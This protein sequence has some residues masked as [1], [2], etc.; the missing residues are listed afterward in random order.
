SNYLATEFEKSFTGK[1][2][3]AEMWVL[4]VAAAN[5]TIFSHGDVNESLELALTS[6]NKMQVT[7]GSK[8]I[9]SA[10]SY[11][12]KPGEWA[13]V[14]VVYNNANQTVSAFYNFVEMIHAAQVNSYS[15][16][17]H[18]EYGRS[19][20][21]TNSYFNGKI[22]EARI[23]ND[24]LNS[25]KLQINSLSVLSGSESALLGYYP[26]NEGKGTVVF[27]KAHG[28]N[29]LLNGL[30]ST[31][32][33][34]AIKLS[35]NGYVKVNTSFAPVTSAMDYTLEMWF[36]ADAS[37]VNA[38]LA[39]NGK[40]D[41]TEFGGSL[42]L[43]NLGFESGLLSF[44][45]NGYKVQADGNYL[46]NKWH[47]VAIAVNRNSGS[48]QLSVDGILNQFF[49]AK[50]LGGIASANT[51]LGV[52]SY[53][54][55]DATTVPKFD[56][57]FTG[58]IDEF[59]IWNTY[60]NQ[61]LISANNN[62]RLQGN[63]LGLLAYYPF[64]TYVMFQGNNNLSYSL[65]DAKV[66]EDPA[67]IVPNASVLNAV[68][69][70]ETAPIKDRG[71]VDNLK[72]DFVV[73][74][75]ALIINLQ[76]PQQA[77]DK[78]VI[79]FKSKNVRDL[80]GNKIVSPITW[81]A[82]IDQNQL[83]WSDKEINLVKEVNTPLTFQSYL[84]N[85][86]GSSQRYSVYNLPSWL[87]ASPSSGSVD[88]K[89]NQKISFSVNEALNIG[90]YE[91]IIFMRN[92]N[93]QTEALKVTLQVKGK[94]P[95]WVVKP[96]DYTYNMA[97]YGKLRL[98]NV[99]SI[100]KEDMLAAFVNGKCVGVATNTYN[101]SNNLWYT[102][103]TVYSNDLTNSNVEFRIWQASTGKTF[104]ATPSRIINFANDAIIG[105]PSVPVIFDGSSLYY[106]DITIN[107]NWNWISFNLVIPANTPVTTTLGNG[108]W[109]TDDVIKN[110]AAGKGFANY[111]SNG[112]WTGSLKTLDNL[113]LYKLKATYAQ[114]LTVNGTPANVTTTAIPLKG[115]QW[116]YISYLP[117]I[118]S[119]LKEALAGYKAVDEDVI[120][121]Q[122]GFAMYSAQNGWIGSL[123]YLE[124]GKGYMLYR[125]RSNDTAF[126][127]P[128]IN[129]SLG[130]RVGA[131]AD[132]LNTG[133]NPVPA[134]FIH[135]D[136][137]TIVAIVAPDFDYRSGDSIIAF[138][139][140]EMRGKS[141]PVYNPEITKNTYFF[142]IGGDAE[143]PVVFM[144]ERNGQIVA[145]SNTIFSYRTNSNIG[146]LRKPVELHFEK[147]SQNITIYPNP[148]NN[149]TN[150]SM[151][152]RGL[153]G[154][155]DHKIQVS[156]IDVA[157]KLV[158]QRPLQTV[159]GTGF[160]TTWNGRSNT[161]SVCSKG[162]Y[163]IN[164]MVD[165]VPHVYKVIKQ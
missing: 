15:G 109:T 19:I 143:Q 130:G 8:V 66:Q 73:N 39:S 2:I 78:T 153:I 60:L 67:A 1:N 127:Y 164:I 38:T 111:T 81:T 115:A 118:N 158:M 139:N 103:L 53:Y 63:E 94:K 23:W 123:T 107:Q 11:D 49:D 36:K 106:K 56:Q 80:N 151:D 133:E 156:I 74:R 85:S 75:D 152:L 72:F 113:S 112:G 28:S 162:T 48:A 59:R 131:G 105:T 148:F 136:N 76:E 82:Y 129:G 117:Q 88:P 69:S 50:N 40:G 125:K 16:T 3:T 122:T 154:T 134:N 34:K 140:G 150:I 135:S 43:F 47:H 68:E 71:P 26:M 55:P 35:G 84:V 99:F 126:Y 96:S 51:Y 90:S 160:T 114:A 12:Y 30:W 13:H 144:V 142:N 95:D 102:F 58:N 32:A 91:E 29:A 6:D 89:G 146:T 145:Q 92:D 17:G 104:S 20:S 93:N 65:K 22:H 155:N 101:A 61:T 83:K 62:V 108:N 31:P 163:F 141:K 37:Q 70:D 159:S 79:T 42:N 87:Q 77:I 124:P 97:V 116:N 41:G 57:Y 137:M 21:K 86:G 149:S 33:G 27:D 161:G 4:P 18:I 10:V 44:R 46:D 119:T 98:N 100:N 157:G 165:G 25:V 24:T 128:A 147:Q 64:E 14:A 7:V 138:V 110:D 54:T 132:I 9:K 5:Q 45:N 52:R 120:K 121:S